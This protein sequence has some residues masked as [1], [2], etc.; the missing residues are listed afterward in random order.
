MMDRCLAVLAAPDVAACLRQVE[1]RVESLERFYGAGRAAVRPFPEAGAIVIK[2]RAGGRAADPVGAT[3]FWGERD[4]V[5]TSASIETTGTRARVAAAPGGPALLYRAGDVVAT[6][7]V[8]AGW[9][10]RGAVELDRGA[11]AEHVAF[12]FVGGARTLVRGVEALAPGVSVE[13]DRGLVR[14]IAGDQRERWRATA[15]PDE[16]LLETLGRRLAGVRPML[17]LTDGADSRVLAVAV[18]E[19]GL[20]VDA[21]TWGDPGWPDVDGAARVARALDGSHRAATASF[22]AGDEALERLDAGARWGDGVTALPLAERNWPGDGPWVVGMGGETGRAFYWR[23]AALLFPRPR[24]SDLLAILDPDARLGPAR[25]EAHDRLRGRVA[26]WIGAARGA[27][28][29]GWG[30]LDVLYAEQRVR[31]WGRSQLPPVAGSIIGG[32]TPAPVA[33][34]LAALPVEERVSDGF[35]RRFVAERRPDLALPVPPAPQPGRL[36]ERVRR[37]FRRR[38]RSA[39]HPGEP[40]GLL[41]AVIADRPELGE[42]VAAVLA[43]DLVRQE[44]GEAWADSVLAGVGDGHRR[45]VERALNACGPYALDAA[46]RRDLRPDAGVGDA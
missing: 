40:D 9:L 21:F 1:S 18:R 29:D 42:H 45:H 24:K 32:F 33:A 30:V 15:P 13:I 19:L 6:H 3:E 2:L 44:L 22:F 46:I 41:R 7:A 20:P 16:A 11:L 28:L 37:A 34:A 39:E 26:E 43:S 10:A 5:G 36:G 35:A 12:D 25:P 23:G 38:R 31:R 27:G 4:P 14:E 8:V 17:A